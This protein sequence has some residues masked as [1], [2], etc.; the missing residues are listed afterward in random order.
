MG[1][2]KVNSFHYK[3]NI[4]LYIILRS[5]ILH[6][7]LKFLVWSTLPSSKPILTVKTEE[8]CHESQ[9]IEVCVEVIAPILEL[10]LKE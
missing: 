10:K 8:F 3:N 1:V 5:K 7:I 9:D 4:L 6:N 2:Y